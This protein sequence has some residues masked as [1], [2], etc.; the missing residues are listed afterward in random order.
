[1]GEIWGDGRD[2]EA[3][4]KEVRKDSQRAE[5]LQAGGRGGL[6]KDTILASSSR[7]ITSF[8]AK[9]QQRL[10]SRVKKAVINKE[11]S[12]KPPSSYEKK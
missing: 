5:Q 2:E 4:G 7:C 3:C 11:V 6:F 10:N 12:F 1:M 8:Q 9:L